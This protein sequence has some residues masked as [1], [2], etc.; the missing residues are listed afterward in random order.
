MKVL[1]QI[2]VN[3]AGQIGVV[4]EIPDVLQTLGILEAAKDI[5][6]AKADQ[7]ANNK[8]GLLIARGSLPN[9]HR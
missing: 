6:K 1:L 3:D 8:P 4:N 5:V 7:E 9:G 2:V